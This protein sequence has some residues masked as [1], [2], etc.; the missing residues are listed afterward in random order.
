MKDE[1]TGEAVSAGYLAAAFE[2]RN[3]KKMA[4]NPCDKTPD[5]PSTGA[6]V[7]TPQY[8]FYQ[9]LALNFSDKLH[10]VE[11]GKL[12]ASDHRPVP[13]FLRSK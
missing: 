9:I 10:S 1:G 3:T 4:E 8:D 5:K 7:R 11:W 6:G 12:E 2:I 13:V